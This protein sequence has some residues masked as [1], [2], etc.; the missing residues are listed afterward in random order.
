[1][2]AF[3]RIIVPRPPEHGGR[4]VAWL[5]GPAARGPTAVC[6]ESGLLMG[7]VEQV[8]GPKEGCWWG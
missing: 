3:V 8:R 7:R 5:C 1:M 6:Q 2:H 4:A